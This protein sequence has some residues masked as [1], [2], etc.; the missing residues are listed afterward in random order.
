MITGRQILN[1][2]NQHE[3]EKYFFGANVPFN[4][5]NYKGPW[6]CAEFV[7]W[8]IYQ[9]TKLKIGVRKN[10]AYTGFWKE[11]VSKYCTKIS[12]SDAALTY[13]AILFRPPGFKGIK[14]GHI[15]ISDGCGGTI[16]AKSTNDGVCKSV[17]KGRIWEYGLLIN[18]VQYEKNNT[19]IF[20][21]NNPPFN[22]YVSNP[23]MKHKVVKE[24]KEKLKKLNLFHGVINEDYDNETAIAV[25]NFQKIK[26]IVVDAVLGKETLT[27]LKVKEYTDLEKNLLWFKNSF[28]DK[29]KNALNN[30]PFDVDLLTAIAYQETGFLWSKMINKTDIDNLLL[31][32]T[33]DTLDSPKRKAFPKNKTELLAHPKGNAMFNIARDALRNVGKWDS[34][35][36]KLFENNPN[37]FCRGYGIFQ[38]DLQFFKSNPNYFLNKEWAN[39]DKCLRIAVEELKSAQHRI[40]TL[41]N[42]VALTEK[43]KIFVTIAYNKG[44]VNVNGSFKQGYKDTLSGKYYGELIYDYYRLSKLL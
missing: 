16:E 12:I 11:D 14:T 8:I 36:K 35:F 22:F 33:G 28:K 32:C 18:S 31:C 39:F 15:V 25:S 24:A 19:L 10:E 1:L 37:K 23:I 38:Y 5:P 21:Y 41:K 7:S 9:L 6:D 2:A 43:E 29:I 30:T 3:G 13:G 27:L 26:G 17:V 44:T 42:K 4:N 34:S 40:P 20:D